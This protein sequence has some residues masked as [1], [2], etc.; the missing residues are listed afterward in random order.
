[1]VYNTF[2]L[3]FEP[4]SFESLLKYNENVEL[5]QLQCKK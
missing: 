2:L 4:K 3:A 1:M 5:V